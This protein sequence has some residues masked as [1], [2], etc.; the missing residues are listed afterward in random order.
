VEIHL[1]AEAVQE[2][3]RRALLLRPPD[4]AEASS[5]V[6]AAQR[7]VVDHAELEHVAEVLVHEPQ[8]V[9]SVVEVVRADLEGL[10]LEPGRGSGI[11][12]VEAGKG[13]DQGRLPGAVLPDQGVDLVGADVQVDVDQRSRAPE[14]LGQVADA[15]QDLAHAKSRFGQHPTRSVAGGRLMP[16]RLISL[17]LTAAR[18]VLK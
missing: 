17:L 2:L 3:A 16:S 12:L 9:M 18:A 6:C 14:R 7:E 5:D 1:D 15:Q 13:F 4:A 8:A 11:R 10:V